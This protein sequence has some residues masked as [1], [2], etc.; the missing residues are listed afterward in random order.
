MWEFNRYW[1]AHGPR[2]H[3]CVRGWWGGN[4]LRSLWRWLMGRATWW[5]RL[6]VTFEFYTRPRDNDRCY[7]PNPLLAHLRGPGPHAR[8]CW[9]T[10]CI[11]RKE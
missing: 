3:L 8:G 1:R 2:R 7:C 10:D 6:L 5:K 9:A 11:L 4:P